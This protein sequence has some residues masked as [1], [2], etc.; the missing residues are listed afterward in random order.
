M[1][2]YIP[3]PFRRFAGNQTYLKAG[4]TVVKCSTDWAA[5]TPAAR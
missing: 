2:A 1:T 4:A 3:T 5:T